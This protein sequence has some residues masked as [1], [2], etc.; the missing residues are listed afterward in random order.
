MNYNGQ[1]CIAIAAFV[2]FE[3]YPSNGEEAAVDD[4]LFTIGADGVFVSLPG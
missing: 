2:A 1:G 4:G 3:V